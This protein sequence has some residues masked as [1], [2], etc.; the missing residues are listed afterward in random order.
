MVGPPSMTPGPFQ[1]AGV[2]PGL[3]SWQTSSDHLSKKIFLAEN[4]SMTCHMQTCSR[5][6]TVQ[7]KAC[8]IQ[9]GALLALV[10]IYN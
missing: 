4:V 8:P 2:P 10:I 3:A 5:D 1:S 7:A 6:C 9:V